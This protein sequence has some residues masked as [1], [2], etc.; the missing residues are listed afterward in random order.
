[1]KALILKDLHYIYKD[2]RKGLTGVN[3]ECEE[4]S[5]VCLIGKNGSGKTTL[6]LHINGLLNGTGLIEVMGIRRSKNTMKEIRQKTGLLF[7][8]VEHH[9]IMPE[10]INDILLGVEAG[11]AGYEKAMEIIGYFNLN[12]YAGTNPLELS[13]GEMKR[14]ALAGILARQPELLLLDEP[15]QNLDRENS[16]KLMDILSSLKVTMLIATHSRFLVENLADQVAVMDSGRI[17]GVY[18]KSKAMKRKDVNDL[19]L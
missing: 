2:G 10:L 15:L 12:R 7:S 18:T 1:M 13:S 3:F 14:A 19:L 5:K 6:L 11:S 16:T 8:Q 4:G 17:T 9:F